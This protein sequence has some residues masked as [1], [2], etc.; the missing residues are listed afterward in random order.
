MSFA[1]SRPNQSSIS[2]DARRPNPAK[3]VS[4]FLL[5]A[6]LLG[7]LASCNYG[8]AAPPTP[9]LLPTAT[10][11]RDVYRVERGSVV[12]QTS[13]AGRVIL[14]DRQDLYFEIPG[15]VQNVYVE[16]GQLLE[17][18]EP[19]ADLAA[20]GREFKVSDA[21]MAVELARER[22]NR[23]EEEWTYDKQT[24]EMELA[25]AQRRMQAL[26]SVVNPDA[27]ELYVQD[28]L[29]QQ[30]ELE[31]ERLER[32][33]NPEPGIELARAELALELANSELAETRLNAPGAGQVLFIKPVDQGSPVTAFETIATLVDPE[34]RQ[35]EA[36]LVA[37]DMASLYEG[38]PVRVRARNGDEHVLDGKI[39]SLPQPVGTGSGTATV[40]EFS[41]SPDVDALRPSMEVEVTAE[42]ARADDV[43]WLPAEA[44][45]EGDD[46][47]SVLVRDGDGVREVEIQ[48]GV[49]G[50]GRMEIERG[51]QEG[52]EVL[53]S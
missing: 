2:V 42:I 49:A 50:G 26:L 29:V 33:M 7:L 19:I 37:A 25:I 12:D 15:R 3:A 44:I 9:V 40:I 16:S 20:A 32:G 21:R 17:V 45:Q 46:G 10:P 23:A 1:P 36:T 27:V 39:V 6:V 11:A 14:G 31:S 4:G 18:D 13:F 43:L 52:E 30:A 8:R 48:V 38:M 5:G 22:V 24:A 34:S 53:G 35:V 28:Q 47:P 51:L 41:D